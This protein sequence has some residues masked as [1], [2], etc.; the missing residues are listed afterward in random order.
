MC[1]RLKVWIVRCEREYLVSGTCQSLNDRSK[2]LRGSA[3]DHYLLLWVNL[4]PEV[5]T[6]V[7]GNGIS[8]S[9]ISLQRGVLVMTIPGR[10]LHSFNGEVWGTEFRRSLDDV[11]GPVL[12]G[13]LVELRPDMELVGQLLPQGSHH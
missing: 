3:R 11:N 5:L 13:E 8:E 4:S 9:R 10:L 2:T 7:L 6:I 12:V 1:D